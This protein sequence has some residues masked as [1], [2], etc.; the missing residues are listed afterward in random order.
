MIVN[1]ARFFVGHIYIFLLSV[2][3]FV[4]FD[5][6]L[7]I[8][9]VLLME[10]IQIWTNS[11]MKKFSADKVCSN[12]NSKVNQGSRI[13]TSCFDLTQSYHLR[14]FHSPAMRGK[15]PCVTDPASSE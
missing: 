10:W 8:Y 2:F 12:S 7:L 6:T 3:A 1:S 5:R 4:Q 11:K 14:S 9:L 13:E 15:G